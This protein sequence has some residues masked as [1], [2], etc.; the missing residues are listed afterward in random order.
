MPGL[1]RRAYD[2]E[3][4]FGTIDSFLLWRLSGGRR[5]RT[6]VTNA[7]RTML[8]DIARLDWDQE[9]LDAFD[10]PR[11]LLPEPRD[12][13]G[14]FG[15]TDP[16][17]IGSAIPVAALAGDQQAA[18]IGQA[19]FR[20]GMVKSTY[21]TGGF[22]LLNIGAVPIGSRH[23][24]LTTIAYR[25]AGRTAYALEGSIFVAGAASRGCATGSARSPPWRRPIA[26]RSGPIRRSGFI[27]CRASPG[28]ARPI[29]RRG[30]GVRC[31]G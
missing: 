18:L 20:S 2:G 19:C 1:R 12:T 6:D 13:G 30:R 11:A 10:I 15:E 4:A 27:W 5:H 28:S 23:R 29:G 9:L 26:W 3:I 24:L 17:L 25:L 22:A 21:G 8:F 31:S 14:E 16:A 7:S